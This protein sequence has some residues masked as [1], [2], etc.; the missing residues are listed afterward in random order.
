VEP[1]SINGLGKISAIDVLQLR[2]IDIQR[3]VQKLGVLSDQLM[4]EVTAA[5]AAVI[6]Y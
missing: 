5:I 3:C 2:S 4:Q 6:E 1:N